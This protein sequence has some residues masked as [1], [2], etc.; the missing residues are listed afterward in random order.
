M[1]VATQRSSVETLTQVCVSIV[2]SNKGWFGYGTYYPKCAGECMLPI[3]DGDAYAAII[4][5]LPQS[6]IYAYAHARCVK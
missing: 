4:T 5:R 3:N 2:R 6:S 1:S